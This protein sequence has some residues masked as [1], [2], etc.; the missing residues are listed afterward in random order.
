M[1]SCIPHRRLLSRADAQSLI[2][3]K[4][5]NGCCRLQQLQALPTCLTRQY[6][7]I[8]RYRI[9]RTNRKSCQR[10]EMNR[11]TLWRNLSEPD[12][13]RMVVCDTE[14]AGT[15]TPVRK[16]RGSPLRI[17]LRRFC[18][19]TIGEL[20]FLYLITSL[21]YLANIC[22]LIPITDRRRSFHAISL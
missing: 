16:I 20:V 12:S 15:D 10:M 8:Y 17:C 21:R 5:P 6:P 14:F 4:Y 2:F 13:C 22:G 1:C 19:N 11:S 18:V 9:D 3:N 7:P